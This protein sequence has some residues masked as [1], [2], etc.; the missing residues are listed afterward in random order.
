MEIENT[1]MRW[2]TI[3]IFNGAIIKL[4]TI[5]FRSINLSRALSEKAVGDRGGE[6]PTSYSR[7]AGTTGAIVMAAMLWA[8]GNTAIFQFMSG[9]YTEV[10]TIMSSL[11]N[12]FLAG[13]SLFAPYAFNQLKG[14]MKS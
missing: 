5:A 14:A 6:I 2:L 7:V 4:L 12:Y 9:K 11:G 8:I 10:S 1:V 3:A 13:A